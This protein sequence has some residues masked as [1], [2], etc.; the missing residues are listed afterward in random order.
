MS[1]VGVIRVEAELRFEF[2]SHGLIVERGV[3]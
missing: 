2:I 1:V 3:R